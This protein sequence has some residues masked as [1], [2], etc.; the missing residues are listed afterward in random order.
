MSVNLERINNS[1]AT[2]TMN[3]LPEITKSKQLYIPVHRRG[4]PESSPEQLQKPRQPKSSKEDVVRRGRGQFRAPS[5]AAST[6]KPQDRE[7][8]NERKN[9][10]KPS[11]QLPAIDKAEEQKQ[12]LDVTE[13]LSA[14]FEKLD[15]A[16]L[17]TSR[18]EPKQNSPEDSAS[19][20]EE[21]EQLLDLSDDEWELTSK[22]RPA[23]KERRR[24]LSGNPQY[25]LLFQHA[26]YLTDELR[27]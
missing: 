5:S 7:D 21:W 8:R 6:L 2:A 26:L 1:A 22:Q 27:A 12:D 10:A 4:T 9:Y 16:P 15:I 19:E 13:E 11:S 17:S 23:E 20:K 14:T 18:Q 25:I 24:E 3:K